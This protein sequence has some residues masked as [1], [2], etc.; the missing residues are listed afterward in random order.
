MTPKSPLAGSQ[1]QLVASEMDVEADDLLAAMLTGRGYQAMAFLP[2]LP[3]AT[4]LH[5]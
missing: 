4:S 1:S 2:T 3:V 5:R